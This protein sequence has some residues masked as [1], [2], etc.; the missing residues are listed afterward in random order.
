M[1]QDTFTAVPTLPGGKVVTQ[2]LAGS[3]HSML[4][5]DDGTV[6]A[7]GWNEVRLI[8]RSLLRFV[9]KQ[10]ATSSSSSCFSQQ[11]QCSILTLP[12]SF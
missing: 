4:L 2:V 9:R 3:N 10:N 1:L 11:L 5:A 6:F 8:G 12:L 7:C